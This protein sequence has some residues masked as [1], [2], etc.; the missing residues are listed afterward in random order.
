MSQPG[1]WDDAERARKRVQELK[2]LKATV[3]PVQELRRRF[4]DLE[5][6]LALTRSEGDHALLPE[7]SR[8]VTE[9]GRALDALALRTVLSGPDDHRGAYFQIQAGAGG[10]ESCDWAEML[11]RMYTRHFERQGYKVRVEELTPN[12]EAG[13]RSVT[14]SVEG[15]YVFGRIKGETGVHRLVRISPFD[16][17]AR[18]HTSFAAVDVTPLFE[19][20]VEV[21]LREE[22][23]KV[24]TYRSSGPGGQHVNKTDSAVRI[25]HLPTG[26]VVQCQSDRSQHRNRATA[27]QM[28]KA[29]LYQLK[30]AEREAAATRAYAAK[31]KIAWGNQIR[32]YVLQPYTLAKDHRTG[33]EVGNVQGVLDGEL[34]PFIEAYLQAQLRE[35]AAGGPTAKP[36]EKQQRQEGEK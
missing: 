18:R 12:E 5:E 33:L 16:A 11:L 25:T 28:L 4:A 30:K 6:L 29:K 32:S 10:T 36:E 15:D 22:D 19:E 23:L 27:L 35:G 2:Q 8:E 9:L 21:D 20:D 17:S 31:G 1:F 34:A 14:L 3:E 13:L 26:I 24:D 7:L